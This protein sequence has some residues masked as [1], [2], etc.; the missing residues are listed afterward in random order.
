M[1]M[2]P[3]VPVPVSRAPPLPRSAVVSTQIMISPDE[4][5]MSQAACAAV[6]VCVHVFRVAAGEPGQ[7][8]DRCVIGAVEAAVAPVVEQLLDIGIGQ[9]RGI[10]GL[11]GARHRP[12]AR[13]VGGEVVRTARPG[14][15]TG[16][17]LIAHIGVVAVGIRDPGISHPDRNSHPPAD[18]TPS[19][20]RRRRRRRRGGMGRTACSR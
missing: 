8:A 1:G 3:M 2:P 4:V 12:L 11:L 14:R 6:P 13:V 19:P 7:G 17:H 18:N 10:A 16:P 20:S 5:Q 15:A 9:Y